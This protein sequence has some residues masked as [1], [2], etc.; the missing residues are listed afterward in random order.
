MKYKDVSRHDIEEEL[1]RLSEEYHGGGKPEISTLR[2]HSDYTRN[3]IKKIFKNW[4][5]AIEKLGHTLTREDILNEL[6]RVSEEV[7]L[8][9]TQEKFSSHS[10][11]EWYNVTNNFDTWVSALRKADVEVMTVQER[12]IDDEKLLESIE[13][14][15]S[16]GLV[17]A[18]KYRKEG[19]YSLATIQRRFGSWSNAVESTS[20]QRAGVPVGEEHWKWSGGWEGYYGESWN[21]MRREARKRDQMRCQACM[22]GENV[23]GRKPDVH[24]IKPTKKFDIMDEHEEMNGLDN[25]ISLCSR[26]HH[27]GVEGKWQDLS[28]QDFAEKAR[29]MR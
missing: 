29:K 2:E 10:N 9:L 6:Q 21:R 5:D 19:K 11:I 12:S 18:N 28:P 24:H 22:R 7:D 1:Q 27:S 17:K 13:E 26:C 14:I 20:C 23:I 25:L 8:P 4:G 16:D 15:A 3:D